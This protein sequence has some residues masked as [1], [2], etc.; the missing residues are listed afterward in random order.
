MTDTATLYRLESGIATITLNRADNKNALS[1]ELMDS[2]GDHL[3]QAIA[4]DAARVIVLTHE[5]NTFCA[6]ADLKGGL[7]VSR[8]NLVQILELIQDS[9][10][11][12]V[13][14]I[15]GHC[16][17]GGVGLAAACD[18]SIASDEVKFA[19][20]EVRI[21]VAPAIIS[22]VCLPKLRYA[23]AMELF[24]GGE[25]IDAPRA[26]AVGL[27]NRAVPAAQ[28]DV[29]LAELIDKLVRGGPKALAAC[30]QLI[31]RVPAMERSAAYAWTSE[32]SMGLF[33]SPEAAAGIMAFRNRSDAPWVPKA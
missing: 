7:R 27:I 6:G 21:G 33:S 1:A 29:A 10:K 4:D 5:G 30:K 8:H 12:V 19:F 9:P 3:Q 28:L 18:L 24:L 32:L 26:A 14:R 11:P 23:D 20:S 25:R 13:A 15:G 16:M 31:R 22:V 2:L 17:G